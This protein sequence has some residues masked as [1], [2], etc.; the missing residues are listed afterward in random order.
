MEE[1]QLSNEIRVENNGMID[2]GSLGSTSWSRSYKDILE[3]E[4]RPSKGITVE[5]NGMEYGYMGSTIWRCSYKDA[6]EEAIKYNNDSFNKLVSMIN[7]DDCYELR[8]WDD[9]LE[10]EILSKAKKHFDYVKEVKKSLR[11]DNC[12]QTNNFKVTIN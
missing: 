8:D 7:S 6:V 3:E 2:D 4:I 11:T 9:I 12:F 1:I 5:N 10:Q